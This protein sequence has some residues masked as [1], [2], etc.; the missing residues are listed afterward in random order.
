LQ[1]AALRNCPIAK[2]ASGADDVSEPVVVP[3]RFVPL[4][5]DALCDPPI[6]WLSLL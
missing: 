6:C 4:T 2:R 1:R 3:A 5:P